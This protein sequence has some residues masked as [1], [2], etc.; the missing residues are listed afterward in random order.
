[1]K[2]KTIILIG[3]LL[4]Q[5]GLFAQKKMDTDS[6]LTV[7]NRYLNV[8]KNYSEVKRLG[9]MGHKLAPT[10]YDFHIALGRACRFTN[11]LDSARYYFNQVIVNTTKYKEAYIYLA[12]IEIETKNAS[13]SKI[14]LDQALK[15]YPDEKEFYWLKLSAIE[16]ENDDP[17][18]MVYLKQFEAKFPNDASIKSRI[19][20]L[21]LNSNSDR[22]GIGTTLTTF[23]R[24]GVG[25]WYLSTIQY[26][27]Q[28]KKVTLIGRLNYSDRQSY[29]NSIGNGTLTE[30]ESYVKWNK[31]HYSFG[32]FGIGSTPLF[33]KLRLNYSS[34]FSFAS[35]WELELGMRYNKN[36]TTENYSSAIGLG[37]YIGSG[38]LNLKSY[39]NLDSQKK[40]PSFTLSYRYYLNSRYDYYTASMGYG[41]SPDERETLSQ[42]EQRIALNSYRVGLGYSKVLYKK[43]ILSLLGNYNRQEYFPKK[44]Q[45]ELSAT[46]QIHYLF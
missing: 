35:K 9:H 34:F 43:Y 18:T 17:Q 40:Y 5:F 45:N 37:T 39:L 44:Y 20:D 11:E 16:M 30:V 23:D 8:D 19:L 31:K 15:I 13:K 36:S 22:I 33:P 38:W 3:S 25:P 32:N 7:T 41:T 6:L 21:K 46:L 12:Q 10:Y 1:M 26:I 2:L 24:S 27:R 14:V 4:V 42:Y 28:R 29:G